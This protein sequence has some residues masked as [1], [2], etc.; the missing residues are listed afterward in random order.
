MEKKNS[1]TLL[2]I[3][4]PLFWLLLTGT[5]IVFYY[6]LRQTESGFTATLYALALWGMTYL[7]HLAIKKLKKIK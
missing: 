4:K 6:S 2:L 1:D 5:F 7:V 3:L